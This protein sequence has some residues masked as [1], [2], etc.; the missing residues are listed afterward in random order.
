M[1]HKNRI[2]ASIDPADKDQIKQKTEQI[3]TLLPFLV[4]LDADER[5]KGQ[6][7]GKRRRDFVEQIVDI[8]NDHPEIL[9]P[10]FDLPEF[11]KDVALEKDLDDILTWAS[12]VRKQIDDTHLMAGREAYQQALKIYK[13]LQAAEGLDELK[14][15]IGEY[16]GKAREEEAEE[17]DAQPEE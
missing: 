11:K 5:K 16:F 2:S 4:D 17:G 10:A 1:S 7:I 6:K 8:A 3:E 12:R 15:K 14:Q 9:P 13:Y